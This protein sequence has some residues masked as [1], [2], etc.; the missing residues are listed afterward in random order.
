MLVVRGAMIQ[1]KKTWFLLCYSILPLFFF[2]SISVLCAEPDSK[3]DDAFPSATG[4]GLKKVHIVETDSEG[5]LSWELWAEKARFI[6]ENE[7]A[8]II[9]FSAILYSQKLKKITLRGDKGKFFHKSRN[10]RIEGKIKVDLQGH[11]LETQTIE[12]DGEKRQAY[13]KTPV[14]IKGERL[15]LDSAS[16]T[17]DVNKQKIDFTGGVV[18]KI[19]VI[20]PDPGKIL[21]DLLPFEE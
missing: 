14:S 21:F 7:E 5:R 17:L 4:L 9:N 6:K 1:A 20:D 18:A 11:Y 19:K 15:S 16:M 8:E 10:V 12:Y 2:L 13:T 3:S